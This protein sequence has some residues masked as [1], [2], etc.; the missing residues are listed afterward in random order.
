MT[1]PLRILP[2]ATARLVNPD[3][4]PPAAS[5]ALFSPLM[6]L[7][8]LCGRR[9]LLSCPQRQSD[10]R[11]GSLKGGL[12]VQPPARRCFERLAYQ[13]SA[14]SKGRRSLSLGI[15]RQSSRTH[16]SPRRSIRHARPVAAW[17]H[18]RRVPYLEARR[19]PSAT[20]LPL[21]PQVYLPSLFGGMTFSPVNR[22]NRSLNVFS[23]ASS[24]NSS[25][26]A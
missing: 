21:E 6:A 20:L 16:P 13:G 8:T 17:G 18:Q 23:S 10:A 5:P 12:G 26:R 25:T 22:S 15:A 9:A 24:T 2:N 11:D 19:Y 7:A 3:K 14:Q 1:A 4:P